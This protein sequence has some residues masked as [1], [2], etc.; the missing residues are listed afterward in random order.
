MK[1]LLTILF[2]TMAVGLQGWAQ[3]ITLKS[4]AIAPDADGSSLAI[5]LN[6][7]AD[8]CKDQ[9]GRV[10]AYFYGADGTALKCFNGQYSTTNGEVATWASFNPPYQSASYTDFTLTIPTSELHCSSGMQQLSYDFAIKSGGRWIYVGKKKYRFDVNIDQ[11]KVKKLIQHN[12]DGSQLVYTYGMCCACV[13]FAGLCNVCQGRGR[14][15][16]GNNPCPKCNGTGQ[17]TYCHGK[18]GVFTSSVTPAPS[19]RTPSSSTKGGYSGGY[20]VAPPSG[21]HSGASSGSSTRKATRTCPSCGGT[22]KGPDQITWAPNYTGTDNS[23]Y[24][25]QCGRTTSAHSHRR[26]TCPVCH[27]KGTI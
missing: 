15:Y 21:S 22:G 16:I 25:P 4:T 12:P 24:C 18:G 7:S 19:K 14:T 13:P 1:H 6:F 5:K 23:V 10:N 9:D 20:P 3:S 8:G 27:G 26:P 17:C 11:G 2:A